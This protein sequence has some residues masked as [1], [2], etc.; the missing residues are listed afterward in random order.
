M[1]R[2]KPDFI[3]EVTYLLPEHGGR[4]WPVHSG[5]KPMI[6][7]AG[8]A[9][10]T[11]AENVF[12]DRADLRAGESAEANITLDSTDYFVNSLYEG[13]MFELYEP[14]RKVGSGIIKKIVA[15]DLAK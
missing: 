14:P 3:A 15:P 13:Q 11:H 9:G 12:T 5:Y 6:K 1:Q 4:H 8:D 2:F 7:F 10:L